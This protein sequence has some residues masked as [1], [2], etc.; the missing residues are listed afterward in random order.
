MAKAHIWY[1]KSFI[2]SRTRQTPAC[3]KHG[4]VTS[5]HRTIQIKLAQANRISLLM[6]HACTHKYSLY[7]YNKVSENSSVLTLVYMRCPPSNKQT[8]PRV[9]A[10]PT[11][12][13]LTISLLSHMLF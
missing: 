11:V 1:P 10:K 12:G 9:C 13:S 5:F 8:C 2:N 3:C 4:N 7:I 6:H